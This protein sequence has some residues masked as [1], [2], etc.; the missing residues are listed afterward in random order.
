MKHS[1]PVALSSR[2]VLTFLL[3]SASLAA[4]DWPTWLGPNGD[5]IAPD[6]GQF[7]S[8]LNK[9]QIAWKAVVGQGYSAVTVA[10]ERAYTLGHDGQSQETIYCL[11]AGS[12]DIIWKHSYSAQL[13]P[14]M[15]PGGPNASPTVT[16]NKVITAS[17]DGQVFCFPADDGAIRWRANLREV[18][19]IELPD[20]G[21]ASTPVVHQGRVL[22]S[23]G[24]VAALDIETGRAVWTSK[25]AYHP[26]YAT[27]VVFESEGKEL[28]AAFDGKGISILS[29]MDGAE[30]S[31]SEHR[32]QY[33][34][35]ATTPFVLENGRRIFISANLSG[36]MLGFDG[37]Q[38]S[39][40]WSSRDIRNNMNNG[41]I[42]D[43]VIYAIDGKQSSSRD[44]FVAINLA[45]G[46][47]K[48]AREDFGYGTVIGVGTTLLALTEPG[49]LVTI[50]P[51]PERY[52][53]ISRRPVLSK[54]CWTNPVYANGRI[55]LRNDAGDVLCLAVD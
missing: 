52:E 51:S 40:I 54:T 53:E 33:D 5:N 48:W 50:K 41:V 36:E 16:G 17:K 26:G 47:L 21:F 9:W 24:K 38:L 7:E 12:G 27:P 11:N 25:T 20:W 30:I 22:F 45:D 35:T 31:R 1:K 43:G 4:H 3:A 29:A 2:I 34:L 14:K 46:Q 8:D 42:Y 18:M 55:Y 13:L 10:G 6:D 37:R 49:E 19:S 39:P 32:A 28:I 15:H 23:A 44:R